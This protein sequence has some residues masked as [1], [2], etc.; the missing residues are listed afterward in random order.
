[1]FSLMSSRLDDAVAAAAG[2]SVSL[3]PEN[4]VLVPGY[5]TRLAAVVTNG[6]VA[7]MQIKQLK[8]SGAGVNKTLQAAE[9]MLPGTDTSAEVKVNIPKTM[10]LTVPSSE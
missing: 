4:A 9:K 1:R 7:E 2:A 8:F 5:D 10:A 3:L 6:G